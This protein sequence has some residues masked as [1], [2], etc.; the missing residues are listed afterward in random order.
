MKCP[1]F[2]RVKYTIH[3]LGNLHLGSQDDQTPSQQRTGEAAG[4]TVWTTTDVAVAQKMDLSP[5]ERAGR[6]SAGGADGGEGGVDVEGGAVVAGPAAVAAL[7][8]GEPAAGGGQQ[9]V[10]DRDPHPA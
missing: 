8:L 4:A 5:V 3:R 2:D 7:G 6:A 9:P 1:A 10:V